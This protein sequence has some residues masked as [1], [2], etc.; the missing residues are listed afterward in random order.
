[1]DVL[2]LPAVGADG[3]LLPG[4]SAG[5]L[6]LPECRPLR[7]VEVSIVGLGRLQ[8]RRGQIPGLKNQS[9]LLTL[10]SFK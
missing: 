9:L 3:L 2:L 5:G 8:L 7:D 1:M 6:R 10:M 4:V